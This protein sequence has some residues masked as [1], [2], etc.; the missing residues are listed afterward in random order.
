MSANRGGVTR[1]CCAHMY[2][3][4]D[5]VRNRFPAFFVVIF[6]IK[7]KQLTKSVS[8]KFQQI[9]SKLYHNKNSITRGQT[10]GP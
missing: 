10:L 9:S 1:A 2:S 8:A 3:V 6:I 5:R 7:P 4:Q